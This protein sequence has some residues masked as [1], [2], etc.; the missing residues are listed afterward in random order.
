[1]DG[2][3][4]AVQV[5]ELKYSKNSAIKNYNKFS[6]DLDLLKT[7]VNQSGKETFTHNELVKMVENELK[8]GV[9]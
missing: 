7:L 1:M 3:K 9:K 4:E 6:P 2:K 8:R 5:K